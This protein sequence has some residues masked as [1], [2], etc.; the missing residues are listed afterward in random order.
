MIEFGPFSYD[1]EARLLHRGDDEIALPTRV[2]AVLESFLKRPGEIVR[3]DDILASAWEGAFVGEDSLTQAVS[4]LRQALGDDPLHPSFIQTIPRRGYR[5]VADV[6]GPLH[7]EPSRRADAVEFETEGV[8]E[9]GGR[10]PT[11]LPAPDHTPARLLGV[12]VIVVALVTV[13]VVFGLWWG[14]QGP[15]GQSAVPLEFEV[16]LPEGQ[17]LVHGPPAQIAV[18]PDGTRFVY[19]VTDGQT[20][21]LVLRE[22]GERE[23][24]RIQGTEGARDPFFSPDGNSIAFFTSS[25]VR[26]VA[27][28]GGQPRQI[29]N[30]PR[31]NLTGVTGD[32]G[33]DDT[34]VLAGYQRGLATVP[35]SGG[36]LEYIT[37]S[38]EEDGRPVAHK[39]PHFLPGGDSLLFT[40]ASATGIRLQGMNLRTG[41]QKVVLEDVGSAWYVDEGYLVYVK[42]GALMAVPFDPGALEIRGEPFVIDTGVAGDW[43][44][45][46]ASVDVS[47]NGAVVF[48][49]SD[50]ATPRRRLL[51][52]TR[53]GREVSITDELR[54]WTAARFSPVDGGMLA[55]TTEELHEIQSW[56]TEIDLFSRSGISLG[57][58]QQRSDR[59]AGRAEGTTGVNPS[60]S[61]DGSISLVVHTIWH[62][63]GERL[64]VAGFG[65]AGYGVYTVPLDSSAGAEVLFE[66][67][68]PGPFVPVCW[69]RD[70]RYLVLNHWTIGA[71]WDIWVYD[72]EEGSPRR[73]SECPTCSGGSL[74]PD[75]RWI[76]YESWE[77]GRWEVQVQPFP[78]G[79][80]P[81][82]VSS[83]GGQ[84]PLWSPQGDEIFFVRGDRLMSARV[85]YEPEFEAREITELF[86]GPYL[87][88]HMGSIIAYDVAPDADSFVIIERDPQPKPRKLVYSRRPFWRRDQR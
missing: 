1:P 49:P 43:V 21:W 65:A 87:Y 62:P 25:Q 79:G 66:P 52:R 19:V 39:R 12:A 50:A 71:G 17:R 83:G 13:G 15:E 45:G 33:A 24:R 82:S 68:A 31:V 60:G 4:Q 32:W 54:G 47:R 53:D 58:T 77:S 2:L 11:T 69:S 35:A 6:S 23:T 38:P 10:D 27:V 61:E 5:F 48:V 55:L 51:R 3:K 26:T 36:P 67:P 22:L 80:R 84:W 28:T 63:S 30:D 85:R 88:H 18:S 74:S 73:F 64:T 7:R 16:I 75:G 76:A 29:A 20:R 42:Q 56:V 34:I 9:S 40:V 44:D 14:G 86:S 57:G 46:G 41:E 37:E 78:E 8:P 70:G 72:N 81:R 59:S